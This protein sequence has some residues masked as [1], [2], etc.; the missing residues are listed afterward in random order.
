MKPPA[1]S[2][3]VCECECECEFE[4]GCVHVHVCVRVFVYMNGWIVFS[5]A[6]IGWNNRKEKESITIKMNSEHILLLMFIWWGKFPPAVK[7]IIYWHLSLVVYRHAKRWWGFSQAKHW[8]QSCSLLTGQHLAW[9][10]FC[11]NDVASVAKVKVK[12]LQP[13]VI[14][15]GEAL[16]RTLW[17]IALSTYTCVCY[18]HMFM[19]MTINSLNKTSLIFPTLSSV[20]YGDAQF[21]R[22]TPTDRHYNFTFCLCWMLIKIMWGCFMFD[23]LNMLRH[24]ASNLTMLCFYRRNFQGA[25]LCTY[26][27]C[28]IH[29]EAPNCHCSCLLSF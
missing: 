27:V 3:F 1:S 25:G 21:L 4:R 8:S 23:M 20:Y 5:S 16:W 2:M 9:K 12:I 13:K 26:L 29:L 22:T 18:L 17:V 19:F 7:L 11:N 28:M 15:K 14:S 6:L 24:S 10:L